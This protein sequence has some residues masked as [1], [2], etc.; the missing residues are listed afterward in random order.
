MVIK[1]VDRNNKGSIVGLVAISNEILMW[2]CFVSNGLPPEVKL[3]I[4]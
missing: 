2:D 3:P 1:A 4:N